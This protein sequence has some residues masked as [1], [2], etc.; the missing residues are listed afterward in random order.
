MHRTTEHDLPD[1][2]RVLDALQ[3]FPSTIA[4]SASIPGRT[5]PIGACRNSPGARVAVTSA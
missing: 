4:R 2:G 1:G 3:R 5:V